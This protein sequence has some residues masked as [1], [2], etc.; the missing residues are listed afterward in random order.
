MSHSQ[1][2]WSIQTRFTHTEGQ[3]TFY[4]I[5]VPTV[6]IQLA[7]CFIHSENFNIF[8]RFSTNTIHYLSANGFFRKWMTS[9][10]IE[11]WVSLGPSYHEARFPPLSRVL[12][13][14]YLDA[15]FTLIGRES[16]LHRLLS[17]D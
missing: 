8:G 13:S 5:K 16:I 14:L 4:W 1:G 15:F 11:A 12:P 10:K 6:I 7:S 3:N 2:V 17:S 9:Q